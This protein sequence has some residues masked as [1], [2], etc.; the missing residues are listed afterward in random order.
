MYQISETWTVLIL[1]Q[2]DLKDEVKKKLKIKD[3]R[4]LKTY[5]SEP[6]TEATKQ[7]VIDVLEEFKHKVSTTAILEKKP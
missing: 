3:D 2:T 5:L 1:N 6:D 4:T 7:S